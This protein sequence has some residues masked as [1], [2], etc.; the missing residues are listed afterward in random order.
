MTEIR[1][2][3]SIRYALLRRGVDEPIAYGS[4]EVP[5]HQRWLAYASPK[6]MSAAMSC[7][8]SGRPGI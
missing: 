8:A 6:T 7:T 5:P 4:S 1:A 2:E 3:G